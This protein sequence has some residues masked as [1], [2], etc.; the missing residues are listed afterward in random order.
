MEYNKQL[1]NSINKIASKYEEL[2]AKLQSANISFSEEKEIKIQLKGYHQ[3]VS[4]FEKFKHLINEG[5]ETEKMLSNQNASLDIEFVEL[6]K[7][8]LDEIKNK[9]PSMEI[10]LKKMLLPADPNKDKDV[11]IEMRP[12]AGGDE[13]AI[14]VTNLFDTYKRYCDS[15]KWTISVT[16]LVANNFGYNYISFIVKGKNVYSKMKFE[17][18]VHRVQRVPFT[19]SKGRVHTSTITVS[20]LPKLN[21]IDYKIN[22]NDLRIDVYRASGAG[23]QHVNRT[24]SAVRITHLPTGIVASCQEGKS[25]IQNRETAMTMLKSKIWFHLSQQQKQDQDKMRKSQ[26]GTGERSE[27]IR[28]Y[29]YPQNRI[30]D[31]RINLTLNK[32]DMIMQSGDLSEIHSQLLA[33]EQTEQ[34]KKLNF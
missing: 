20:V 5:L 27:K 3:V 17:S 32:L 26:V 23:G 9:I 24:E 33:N 18:G 34:I 11:I 28:T 7:K 29:N 15:Q 30:T 8:E 2:N 31:H 6:A 10:E 19:E 4:E 12:A 16:E 22:P 13:S 14:F 25:Q 21:E 1:Y